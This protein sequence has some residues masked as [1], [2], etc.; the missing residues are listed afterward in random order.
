MFKIDKKLVSSYTG[1][2]LISREKKIQAVSSNISNILNIDNKK[3]Y[4]LNSMG[5]DMT[6]IAP[7]VFDLEIS[8]QKVIDWNMPDVE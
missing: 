8:Q 3:L 7:E 1:F 4:K 2:M 6:K 5:Y